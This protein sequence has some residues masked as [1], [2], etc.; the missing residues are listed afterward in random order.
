MPLIPVRI[1]VSGDSFQGCVCVRIVWSLRH[2][3]SS[4]SDVLVQGQT[5]EGEARVSIPEAASCIPHPQ[6]VMFWRLEC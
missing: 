6:H 4:G 1:D 3:L 5:P 2:S